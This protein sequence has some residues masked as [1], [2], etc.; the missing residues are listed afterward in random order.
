MGRWV[1]I[2]VIARGKKRCKRV[3]L[4]THN[5]E[6]MHN[7][8]HSPNHVTNLKVKTAIYQLDWHDKE[9]CDKNGRGI[10]IAICTVIELLTLSC[11]W[12]ASLTAETD[13]WM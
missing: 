6:I 7:T 8:Y 2:V 3:W 13:W 12:E 5:F 11:L 1:V 10:L 9:P 4:G